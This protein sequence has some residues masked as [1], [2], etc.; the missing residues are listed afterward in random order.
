MPRPQL[1]R[2]IHHPILSAMLLA[3]GTLLFACRANPS[4]EPRNIGRIEAHDARFNELVSSDA[5]IEILADGFRWSEGPVWIEDGDYILFS[6]VP[7]NT[8]Y[9]WSDSEGLIQWLSPSG[10]TGSASRNASNG[11]NGLTLDADGRLILA[12]HGDRRVARLD[13]PLGSPTPTFVTVADGW[14]GK[15]FN[16]PN[17]LVYDSAG[18]LYITDPPYGLPEGANSP[19]KELPFSGVYR[20]DPAGLVALISDE[21]KFPNGI[22]LS[23]D[24]SRLYVTNSEAGRKLLVFF[25][26]LDEGRFGK[27]SVL[28]DMSDFPGDG[29]PDGLKVDAGGNIFTTGPDGVHVFAPDGTLLGTIH[30]EVRTANCAWGDDGSSLYI[31]GHMFLL[32]VRTLTRGDRFPAGQ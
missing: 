23:P 31:T 1:R 28:A 26:R 30:T 7:A 8:I 16:S 13:A 14:D 6:D 17:D 2:N 5:V 19:D 29:A 10:Y 32:R 24:E 18:N 15:R 27:M 12:Q 20:I 25:E 11:S 9:R 22:A 3:A 21:L 4:S